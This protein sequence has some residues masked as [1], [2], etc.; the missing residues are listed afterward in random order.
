MFKYIRQCYLTRR[1]VHE[2]NGYYHNVWKTRSSAVAE[3]YFAL[4]EGRADR[5]AMNAFV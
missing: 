1:S 3:E 5:P 2:L 4:R